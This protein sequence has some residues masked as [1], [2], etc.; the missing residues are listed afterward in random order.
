MEKLNLLTLSL[1]LPLSTMTDIMESVK[2]T[3]NPSEPAVA[4]TEAPAPISPGAVAWMA[5]I[6][7]EAEEEQR[8]RD[9]I[10]SIFE[11]LPAQEPKD[12]VEIDVGE[13]EAE[14]DEGSECG[15]DQCQGNYDD[16]EYLCF[17]GLCY[18]QTCWDCIRRGEYYSREVGFDLADEF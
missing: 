3:T 17:A 9:R 7:E 13:K 12:Y 18:D 11:D 15:C 16:G 8:E 14:E 4:P 1:P 5:T 2:N 10:A 6:L